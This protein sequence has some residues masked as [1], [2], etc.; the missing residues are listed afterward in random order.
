[1]MGRR[2]EEADRFGLTATPL[3]AGLGSNDGRR[4]GRSQSRVFVRQ[5]R[6]GDTSNDGPP[7]EKKPISASARVRPAP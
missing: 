5:S 2:Q 3:P 4:R 7:A 6:D 1:M